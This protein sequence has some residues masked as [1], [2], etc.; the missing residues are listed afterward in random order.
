MNEN[1]MILN[2]LLKAVH[3]Q[4]MVNEDGSCVIHF[5]SGLQGVVV[6]VED[7]VWIYI[8][9]IEVDKYADHIGKLLKKALTL[10]CFQIETK[11]GCL[12]LSPGCESIL[13][14]CSTSFDQL[15]DI[16]FRNFLSNIEQVSLGLKEKLIA[17]LGDA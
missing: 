8:H 14:S 3:P 17:N 16:A 7:A 15:D 4:L 2:L 9:L 11:E 10:N 6:L 1:A 5:G 12:A 13:Y